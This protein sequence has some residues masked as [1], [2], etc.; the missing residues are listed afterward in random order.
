MKDS[1]NQFRCSKCKTMVK[2]GAK[3]CSQCGIKLEWPEKKK[4]AQ[5]GTEKRMVKL[6]VDFRAVDALYERSLS[7]AV[8]AIILGVGGIVIYLLV[9]ALDHK[10]GFIMIFAY[11]VEAIM[12][13]TTFYLRLYLQEWL[14]WLVR[15]DRHTK[16][17]NDISITKIKMIKSCCNISRLLI[18]FYCIL[19]CDMLL[20]N[21]LI[22]SVTLLIYVAIFLTYV[23]GFVTSELSAIA[24]NKVLRSIKS[25]R[26]YIYDGSKKYT[27][28]SG[29]FKWT[30][31][32]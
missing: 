24:A 29:N 25:N 27:T 12:G 5:L 18:F 28:Y 13:A 26:E 22:D 3:Y 16:T 4:N 1:S 14:K 23:A 21:P 8:F 6:N 2:I 32:F 15:P 10:Y 30:D 7:Y 9:N 20:T 11:G 17:K 19:L 31:L